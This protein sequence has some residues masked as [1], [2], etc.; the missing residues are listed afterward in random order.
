[1]TPTDRPRARATSFGRAAEG[2]T[3]RELLVEHRAT[4]LAAA[5]AQ[6]EPAATTS[7]QLKVRAKRA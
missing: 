7:P 4:L 3:D 1:M 6:N 5:W 2:R